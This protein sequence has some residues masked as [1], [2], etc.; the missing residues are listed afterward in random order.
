M[1]VVATFPSGVCAAHT[2][3]FVF[4]ESSNVTSLAIPAF[5]SLVD[6]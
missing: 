6:V 5:L 1:E 4:C 2:F 3:F